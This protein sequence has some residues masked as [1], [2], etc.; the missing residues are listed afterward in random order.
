M[1]GAFGHQ[2]LA[3][4]RGA[5][6]NGDAACGG[7]GSVLLEQGPVGMGYGGDQKFGQLHGMGGWAVQAVAKLN[8]RQRC[9]IDQRIAMAQDDRPPGAHEIDIAVAVDVRDAS[10]LAAGE[11]L[12]IALR[13]R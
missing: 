6:R 2:D 5:A 11:I 9:R 3:A 7:V 4:F 13:K 12:R 10:I 8:L 1:I